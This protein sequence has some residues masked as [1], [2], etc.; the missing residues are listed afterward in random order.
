MHQTPTWAVPGLKFSCLSEKD[1]NFS[2]KYLNYY[3]ERNNFLNR[4]SAKYATFVFDTF[5]VYSSTLG[6]GNDLHFDFYTVQLLLS[7]E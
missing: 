4:F 7:I 5:K 1:L 2:F 3:P 6:A